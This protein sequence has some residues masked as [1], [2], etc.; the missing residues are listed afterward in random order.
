MPCTL[1][2]Y[3]CYNITESVIVLKGVG[4]LLVTHLRCGRCSRTF[5]D[6]QEIHS[7]IITEVSVVRCA[8][9]AAMHG[10]RMHDTL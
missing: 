6:I 4:I 1:P 10:S 9:A 8:R 3:Y 5:L 7:A 2:C